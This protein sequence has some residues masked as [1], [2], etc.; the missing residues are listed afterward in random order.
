MTSFSYLLV[1]FTMN[2]THGFA[3]GVN[4]PQFVSGPYKTE[5]ECTAHLQ[6]DTVPQLADGVGENRTVR[7]YECIAVED[8]KIT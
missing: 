3:P 4:I 7:E 6:A 1:F 2:A 5:V 8:D